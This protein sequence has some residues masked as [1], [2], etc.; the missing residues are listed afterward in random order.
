MLPLA[1]L[2]ASACFGKF[3]LGVTQTIEP[4]P[5]LPGASVRQEVTVDADGLLGSAVKQ[6]MTDAATKGTAQGQGTTGWQIKDNS[7]GPNV[8]I[9]LTRTVSLAEAQRVVEKTSTGG[10][11]VGTIVVRADDWGLARHYTVRIAVSPGSSTPAAPTSSQ[12]NDAT[13]QQLAKALLSGITYDYFLSLPGFVTST[14]GTSAEQSRLVWHMDL[15]STSERVLTAESIYLDWMR[16]VLVI[17]IVAVGA[18]GIWYMQRARQ[19][20]TVEPPPDSTAQPPVV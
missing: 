8:K 9:R 2:L 16:I 5:L 14:N 10:F 12:P 13:S 7:D 6:A 20:V 3:A 19:P 17:V 4:T 15:T 18:G 11:D 1:G